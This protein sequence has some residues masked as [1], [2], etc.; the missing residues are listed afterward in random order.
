MPAS[1][2]LSKLSD[3]KKNFVVEKNVYNAEIKK[4]NIEGKILN[5]TNLATKTTLSPK[6]NEVK[7]EIPNN[8][9]LATTSALTAAKNE[10]PSV[11]NLVKKLT[12]TQNLMKLKKKILII[13]MIDYYCSRI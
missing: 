5:I 12:T 7:G 1:I 8:T 3:V 4:K 10:I 2:D 11:S 6:I 9:K 13:I